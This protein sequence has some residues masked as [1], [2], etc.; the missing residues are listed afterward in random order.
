MHCRF[1]NYQKNIIFSGNAVDKQALVHSG[2]KPRCV[3]SSVCMRY[4]ES[5]KLSQEKQ[6]SRSEKNVL[7]VFFL[8]GISIKTATE[9]QSPWLQ[10]EL[11]ET[12][13]FNLARLSCTHMRVSRSGGIHRNLL[14]CDFSHSTC[15]WILAKWKESYFASIDNKAKLRLRKE[16]L[17]N[18]IVFM[19]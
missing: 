7:R 12:M 6:C 19:W 18:F 16:T 15:W 4:L 10:P 3:L 17:S 14:L 8:R 2:E 1:W 5:M 11:I 9:Q 13:F